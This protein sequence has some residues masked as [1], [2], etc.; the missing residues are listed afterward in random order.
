MKKNSLVVYLLTVVLFLP[1]IGW[2]QSNDEMPLLENPVTVTWLKKNLSKKSP[3]LILTPAIEQQLKAKLKTDAPA[4]AF[5]RAIKADATAILQKPLLEHKLQGRRLLSVSR[6]M[7]SRMGTLCLVYRIDKEPTVLKRINQEL[8]TVCSFPDW[9][10]SHFLDV[11][12]MS[13]AVALAIDWAGSFLPA[14]TVAA[15]KTALIEKGIRPSYNGRMSWIKGTN[16]WNQV[17]NGGMI[18]A[19][20]AIAEKDPKL[21]AETIA[22]SLDGMPYA[23]KEYLPDGIYPEGATYWGYGTSYSI[24]TSSMLTTAFG[25]DFGLSEY[26]AFLESAT[27]RLLVTAP[28]GWFFNYA[29]CGDRETGSGAIPLAWFAAQT[30]NSLYYQPDYFLNAVDTRGET[31]RFAAQGLVWLAQ[32]NTASRTELPEVW[33]GGGD[34]PLVI[35]RGKKE[36]PGQY[37]FGGKG[38]R[39]TISHGNMDAG[40]FI[41]ELDGVRWVVDPGNQGYNELEQIGFDLW[42]RCQTCERWQLLTKGNHGHSTLTVNGERHKADGFAPITD[43]KEL[44]VPEATID[45][46][47]VFDSLLKQATRRFVKESDRSLLISDQFEL[48]ENTRNITWQLMTTADVIPIPGGALLKQDGKQ[49]KLEIIAPQNLSV[50]IVSLDPPPLK[51]DRRIPNLKRVEIEMPAYLFPDGKGKVTVKLS[52]E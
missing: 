16:N 9:N 20:I 47:A 39:A 26:P 19:S 32:V 12:E 43:Y 18:A 13:F 29:D 40:S 31:S 2:S 49:L 42:G 1:L 17:C 27:F 6:E 5:Y 41:F 21:A 10:P 50:S 8:T 36:D 44:P 11:A 34:N 46:T 3:R 30:G 4:Q 14:A 51:I 45:L 28:S 23:L 7:V 37:Y 24:L 52:G 35:F 38:G 22:R 15:A 25:T 33:H 48:L